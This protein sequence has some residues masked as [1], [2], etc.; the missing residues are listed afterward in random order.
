MCESELR[1]CSAPLAP[2]GL[3]VGQFFSSKSML[4]CQTMPAL[5]LLASPSS[6]SSPSSC[7]SS[8]LAC[9]P[10]NARASPGS[11]AVVHYIILSVTL[12]RKT[13]KNQQFIGLNSCRDRSAAVFGGIF[14]LG[15]D[16]KV[17][18][19]VGFFGH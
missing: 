11:L 19:Q 17:Y 15:L 6:P 10:Q 3:H 8:H 1:M 12:L 16:T 5:R 7:S 18:S 13:S 9:Q 2:T 14:T 4:T